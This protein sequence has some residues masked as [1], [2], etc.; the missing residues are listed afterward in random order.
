[1]ASQ[2]IPLIVSSYHLPPGCGGAWQTC[3][4]IKVPTVKNNP[5][6]FILS[7][8]NIIMLIRVNYQTQLELIAIS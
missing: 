2:Y 5:A 3:V 8:F 1:M 6:N 7:T 4:I